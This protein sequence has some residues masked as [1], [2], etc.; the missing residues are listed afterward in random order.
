MPRFSWSCSQPASQYQESICC[1]NYRRISG[2]TLEKADYHVQFTNVANDLVAGD[3]VGKTCNL[4][5]HS[6]RPQMEN[7]MEA[8]SSKLGV[9]MGN[10]TTTFFGLPVIIGLINQG[11]QNINLLLLDQIPTSNSRYLF[12]VTYVYLYLQRRKPTA[13]NEHG[14]LIRSQNV[15]LS[16]YVCQTRLKSFLCNHRESWQAKTCRLVKARKIRSNP[17]ACRAQQCRKHS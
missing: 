10:Q 15:C 5:A 9:S 17:Q 7:G 6:T 14:S 16:R 2:W 4:F 3:S 8:L 12:L 11:K 1:S 13:T